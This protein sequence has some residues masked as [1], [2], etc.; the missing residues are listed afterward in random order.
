MWF[1]SYTAA[2]FET[3]IWP[4]LGFIFMPFTTCAY[5]IAINAVGEISGWGLA[6]VIIGVVLD[7]GGHGGSA[8]S[9]YRLR[10]E[11]RG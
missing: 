8:S 5:A 11:R 3:R 2:A 10:I 6:L 1:T 7:L 9:G 4:L